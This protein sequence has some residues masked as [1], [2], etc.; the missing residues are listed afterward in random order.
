LGLKKEEVYDVEVPEYDEENYYTE[1]LKGFDSGTLDAAIITIGEEADI[2]QDL[3][4]RGQCEILGIPH[5]TALTSKHVYL[6][7]YTIP[8]G[9][10]G[11]GQNARP[12]TDIET[13]ATSA[14]LLTRADAPSH[15]VNAVA[16]IVLDKDFARE[17]HLKEL[18]D[19]QGFA[20]AQQKP[21]FR[22]HK[23]ALQV[24]GPAFDISMF[25]SLDA[26]YSLSASG[27]LLLFVGYRWMQNRRVRKRE[28]KL[29]RY[30]RA[31]LDIEKRQTQLDRRFAATG[32]EIGKLQD[33][34]DEVTAL[35]QEALGEFTAHELEEDRASDCFISMCH[36]LSNKINAK[37]SRQRFDILLTQL[38]SQEREG[39]PARIGNET[40]RVE[41]SI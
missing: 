1:V 5:C 23:G 31:L 10:Y 8:A 9:R 14:Q 33:L 25:E 3:V 27:I 35:R 30:I 2:F 24:Y 36:A 4:Q 37:L 32:E 20:F 7:K 41:G 21:E 16:R 19:D 18:F 22:V 6:T 38:L 40:T 34:L 13:V 28:H 29:D 15:L 39:G 26:A 17:N 11:V 12:E